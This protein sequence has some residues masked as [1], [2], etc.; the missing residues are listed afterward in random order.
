MTNSTKR[1]AKLR[2]RRK[3]AGWTILHIH[4]PP[5]ASKVLAE[6]AK[7]LGRTKAE[8][9]KDAIYLY[10]DPGVKMTA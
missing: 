3:A 5:D 7:R 9:V 6:G 4:L 2:A 10:I 1:T 8:I